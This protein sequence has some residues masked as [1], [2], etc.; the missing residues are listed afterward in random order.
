MTAR[1]YREIGNKLHDLL[2]REGLTQTDL[3]NALGFSIPAVNSWV[4]GTRAPN[5]LNCMKL[6]KYFGLQR[7]YFDSAD[8][9]IQEPLSFDEGTKRLHLI[10]QAMDMCKQGQISEEMLS[11]IIDSIKS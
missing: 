11:K 6:E 7:G 1:P 5:R 2:N 4:N 3:A 10:E 9:V 8:V